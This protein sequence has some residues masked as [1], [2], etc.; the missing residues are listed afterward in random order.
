MAK[1][2]KSD[3]QLVKLS[4]WGSV[5]NLVRRMGE[6]QRDIENAEA[7]AQKKSDTIK[8]Q[9]AKDVKPAQDGITIYTESIEAWVVAHRDEFGKNKQSR[10]LNN[11]TVGW[12]KSTVISVKKATVELIKQVFGRKAGQYVHVKET[13]DKEAMAKLT[14]GQL[15]TVGARRKHKDVFFVEPDTVEAANHG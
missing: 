8:A 4:G 14:D 1:R 11:G 10:K 7:N 6:L 15:A 12:R 13:P 3:K 5:D 2:V 9:L